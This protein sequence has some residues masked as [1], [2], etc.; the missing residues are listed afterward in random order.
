MPLYSCVSITSVKSSACCPS[1]ETL[2]MRRPPDAAGAHAGWIEFPAGPVNAILAADDRHPGE[3]YHDAENEI[4]KR[5]KRYHGDEHGT[6]GVMHRQCALGPNAVD[7]QAKIQ[8]G[9][10]R[11]KLPKACHR[12]SSRRTYAD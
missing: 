12:H 6:S 4:G 2:T 7:R 5:E 10:D 3:E 1:D 9:K 8:D 11:T